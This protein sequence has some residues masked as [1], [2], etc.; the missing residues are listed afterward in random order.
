[1]RQSCSVDSSSNL[2]I[3]LAAFLAASALSH[4]RYLIFLSARSLA[5]YPVRLANLVVSSSPE[6]GPGLLP[7]VESSCELPRASK[8][9]HASC[10]DASRR[11][12]SGLHAKNGRIRNL[13]FPSSACT[14]R[15]PA[16]LP[17]TFKFE[18]ATGASPN[19]A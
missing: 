15:I 9:M 2:A 18:I 13:R 8:R 17:E 5:P 16:L 1:M 11:S 3:L 7:I 10:F 12:G 4:S 19:F 14:Y 6:E